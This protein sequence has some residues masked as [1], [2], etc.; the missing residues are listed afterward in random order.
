MKNETGSYDFHGKNM[1]LS[2]KNES[3]SYDFHDKRKWVLTE[4]N[5]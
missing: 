5:R 4:S 2:M 3:E 1:K